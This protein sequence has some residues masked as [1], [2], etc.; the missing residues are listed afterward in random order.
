MYETNYRLNER[1]RDLAYNKMEQ[2]NCID[3]EVG[4]R[5]QLAAAQI[6]EKKLQQ[7]EAHARAQAE[8]HTFQ[9]KVSEGSKKIA[10]VT[11]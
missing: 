5:L 1:S 9:P 4:E 2:D 7:A 11:F 6:A 3:L 10:E 8:A